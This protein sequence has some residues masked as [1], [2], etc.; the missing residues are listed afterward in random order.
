VTATIGLRDARGGHL[1][2][3][4]DRWLADAETDDLDVLDGAR[5]PVLDIGCGPGRHVAELARRGLPALGID[6][7][8]RALEI[9]RHRGA[10]VLHRSVFDRIPAAGRWRTAL[11]LDGN[12]GIGGDPHTLLRRVRTLLADD[13]ILL[14]ELAPPRSSRPVQ[15][16]RL[17]ID[18]E[19]GPLFHWTRVAFDRI[20]AV[21]AT[22]GFVVS[23]RW[24]TGARWFARLEPTAAP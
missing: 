5:G 1:T 20:D 17:D 9:A 6:I 19:L 11:L 4:A 21:A 18:G 3:A 22:A 8:P 14:V 2:A 10:A 7:T 23:D 16:V 13:G 12:I 15:R 24:S